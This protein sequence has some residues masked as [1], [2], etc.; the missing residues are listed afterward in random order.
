MTLPEQCPH[1]NASFR[2]GEIPP[3][4]REE[5]EGQTHYSRLMALE[6]NDKPRFWRCWKCECHWEIKPTRKKAVVWWECD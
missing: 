4:K 6:I 3:H 1:C 5:Y 2:G